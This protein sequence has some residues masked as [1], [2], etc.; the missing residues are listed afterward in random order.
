MDPLTDHRLRRYLNDRQ[1]GMNRVIAERI[2]LL[3]DGLGTQNPYSLGYPM[4]KDFDHAFL[5]SFLDL[6]LNNLG[7][8][9]VD[10]RYGLNTKAFEREV[11][12]YFARYFRA[13]A[14]DFWGYVTA[15]GTES[16]LFGLALA[17][18]LHPEAVVLYSAAAHYSV[19]KSCRLLRMTAREVA[20]QDH[21]EI[22][23]ADFTSQLD[24][25][26]ERGAI[27]V[28]NVGTTMT[29]AKDDALR[30]RAA[31]DHAGIALRHI[32]ADAAFCGPFLHHSGY[33]GGFDFD[34]GVDSI[35]FSGHKF[36]GAPMP[37]GVVLTRKS[38]SERAHGEVPYIGG[39][40]STLSG[41]RNALAVLCLWFAVHQ[42]GSEGI[43]HRYRDGEA[44]ARFVQAALCDVG[45]SAWRNPHALTVVFGPVRP[46]IQNK[47]QLASDSRHAHLVAMPN[48]PMALLNEF[49]NDMQNFARS[50]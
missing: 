16:N 47:W 10:G 35:A 9:F 31:L 4:A 8:P 33:Q 13:P 46:E 6:P 38:L 24:G 5:A 23:Y 11:I 21:G 41:S 15:G 32:H 37:C 44:K 29:E 28:A 40:D 25:L 2:R 42:W 43:A 48:T 50:G 20:V 1:G 17:R 27:V 34:H 30:L 7:D 12:E 18:E 26:R 22:D 49:V 39:T 14:D 45:V 3:L 36:L 19:P